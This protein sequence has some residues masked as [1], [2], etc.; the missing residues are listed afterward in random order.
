M[1]SIMRLLNE[2]PFRVGG[3]VLSMLFSCSWREPSSSALYNLHVLF[4]MVFE[5]IIKAPE[6]PVGADVIY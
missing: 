4:G 6:S 3:F 1:I 5:I 2:P